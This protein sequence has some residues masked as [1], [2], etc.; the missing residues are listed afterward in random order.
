MKVFISWSGERSQ[1]LAVALRDWL[2]LVLHYAE[3]WLSTSD[4]KSGDRWGNE[5]AKGL[6]ESNFGIICVTKDNLD[7]P[8]LLFEA[9]ALAK[10][11]E[12]GRVIPLRLDLEVSEISGPLTQ[13]QSEKADED[14]IRRLVSSLNKAAASPISDERLNLLFEPMWQQIGTKI[15]AVPPSGSSQKRARPQADILEELVSGIRSVEMRV[16][17]ITDDESISRRK[18]KR[19][20]HPEMLMELRHRVASGPDDP[21]QIL[22]IASFFRDDLPWLYELALEAYRS[23]RSGNRSNASASYR[24]FRQ[25]IEMLRRGPMLDMLGMDSRMTHM[26]LVDLMETMPPFDL[27]AEFPEPKKVVKRPKMTRAEE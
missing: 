9:G 17:D 15:S 10:S 12:D 6:Q 13:F 2:P 5:I 14:G 23:I 26:L 8:W 3:P 7:A 22:L 21:I 4:I 18:Y 25:G 19:R 16:R 11:M 24:R 27:E 1:A 20:P